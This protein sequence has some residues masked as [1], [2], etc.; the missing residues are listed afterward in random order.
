MEYLFRSLMFVPAN[1][2]HLLESALHRGADVLVLDIED[3]VPP[4]EKQQARENVKSFAAKV[5]EMGYRGGY[6]Y[7]LMTE[8]VE[9]CYKMCI[10]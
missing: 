1:N 5:R 10:N 6:S 8:K 3:S 9:N 2:E 7:V 4:A